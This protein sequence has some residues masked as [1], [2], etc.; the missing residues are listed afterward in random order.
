MEISIAYTCDLVQ[1]RELRVS[2]NAFAA[3]GF[4][5][6]S[7]NARALAFA[8]VEG[9][10]KGFQKE[11]LYRIGESARDLDSARAPLHAQ[12]RRF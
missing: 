10:V 11:L 12:I 4:V 9:Q 6:W 1:K 3:R 2:V 5:Q 7:G 8:I